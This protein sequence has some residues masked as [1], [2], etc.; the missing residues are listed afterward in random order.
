MLIISPTRQ[1]YL[2]GLIW[3][4]LIENHLMLLQIKYWCIGPYGLR[5][6]N[7]FPI[8]A[9]AKHLKLQGGAFTAMFIDESGQIKQSLLRSSKDH[10][11]QII[12]KSG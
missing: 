10:M 12:F 2:R 1:N 8:I 9:C 7:N 4:I 11:C 5:K 3:T 6:E